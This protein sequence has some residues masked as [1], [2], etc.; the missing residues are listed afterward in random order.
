[1]L[2][3][4]QLTCVSVRLFREVGGGGGEEWGEKDFPVFITVFSFA[5]SV[6]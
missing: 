5:S 3:D 4:N 1:M 6:S 2:D